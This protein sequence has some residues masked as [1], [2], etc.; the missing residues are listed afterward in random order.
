LKLSQA[1]PYNSFV[2]KECWLVTGGAGYIGS[3][4]VDLLLE[5][6]RKVVI[7]D[8][9]ITG[10]ESRVEYLERKHDTKIAFVKA[11]MRDC[12]LLEKTLVDFEPKGVVHT[13]AL[14]SVSESFVEASKYFDVNFNATKDLTNLMTKYQIRELVF[15]STAAVYGS[16]SHTNFV[17]EDDPTNPISPYGDSKLAAEKVATEF[18]SHEGNRGMSL[19]FFNVVGTESRNLLDNSKDNLIPILLDRIRLNKDPVIYGIDYPTKDGTCVRDYVD[20]R[21]IARAHLS[22]LN[23]SGA[24]SPVVNIGSGIGTSVR[25]IINLVY[26]IRGLPAP[27]ALEIDRRIGDPAILCA[28]VS[29]AFKELGF[30]AKFDI[31]ES[32]SSMIE[33]RFSDNSI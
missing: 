23:F 21:D 16:Q 9:L 33:A 11:D 19:R 30:E 7:Y 18:L 24:L 31:R 4:I 32:I 14:K 6:R 3:H 20:V 29:L 22:L 17:K 25:E 13:A 2:D 10:L 26:S 1:Q 15:S 12:D 8:S 5:S 28:D 27:N